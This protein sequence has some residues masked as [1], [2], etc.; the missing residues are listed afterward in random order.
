[1][2]TWLQTRTGGEKHGAL[3]LHPH[4]G[5]QLLKLRSLVEERAQGPF[6]RRVRCFRL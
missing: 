5:L 6:A 2:Q 4:S 3:W 1:M